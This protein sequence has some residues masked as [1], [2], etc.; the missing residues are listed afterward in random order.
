MSTINYLYL[1]II[2]TITI[3][4]NSEANENLENKY[5]TNESS[6]VDI[7]NTEEI[8]GIWKIKK[9][10]G[11]LMV[12]VSPDAPTVNAPLDI[13]NDKVFDFTNQGIITIKDGQNIMLKGDYTFQNGALIVP[14]YGGNHPMQVTINGNE[15][16]MTQTP[17]NYYSLMSEQNNMTLEQVKNQFIIKDPIVFHLIKQ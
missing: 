2:A 15:M 4:C 11:K 3:S 16:K 8:V 14:K 9:V 6:N 1:L 13:W 12:K 5:P 17:E 10:E 7:L